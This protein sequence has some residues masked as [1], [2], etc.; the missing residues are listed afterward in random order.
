MWKSLEFLNQDYKNYFVNT[1][2]E[3]KK[4]YKTK[5]KV[6]SKRPNANG[7]L[8]ANL[9][10]KDYPIH[11]LVA[12]AFIDNPLNKE[13]VNHIDYD[14]TNNNVKNLE[15]ATRKEQVSNDIYKS[16]RGHKVN[17][18]DLEGN[19][20]HTFVSIKEA[21]RNGFDCRAISNILKRKLNDGYPCKTHKNYIWKYAECND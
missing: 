2:G 14:K 11:R 5:E 12:L 10:G 19:L 18:Y 9:N 4:V 21:G 3:V 16:I 17:A 6:L 13:T 8:R 15:W 20:K 7:Y 1:E